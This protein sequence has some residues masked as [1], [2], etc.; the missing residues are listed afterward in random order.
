[1]RHAKNPVY[2]HFGFFFFFRMHCIAYQRSSVSQSTSQF[3]RFE[4]RFDI[5]PSSIA[6]P[7]PS[8]SLWLLLL[9]SSQEFMVKIYTHKKTTRYVNS[10]LE[11][12]LWSSVILSN[13]FNFGFGKQPIVCFLKH[14]RIQERIITKFMCLFRISL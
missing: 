8:S 10:S 13:G 3:I 1:M 9:L 11:S 7:S 5:C 2:T 12:A 14:K 6:S 4:K